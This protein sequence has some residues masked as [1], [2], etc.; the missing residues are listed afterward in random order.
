MYNNCTNEQMYK[1]ITYAN[2]AGKAGEVGSWEEAE[3][4]LSHF[5]S[6]MNSRGVPSNTMKPE[7]CL[8]NDGEHSGVCL[9]TL[10]I[11]PNQF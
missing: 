5:A 11:P 3:E 9:D 8:Q 1:C 2:I 10:F 7:Y 6:L 4:R